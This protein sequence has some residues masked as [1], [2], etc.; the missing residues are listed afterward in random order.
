MFAVAVRMANKNYIGKKCGVIRLTRVGKCPT[1]KA[2][3]ETSYTD[4]FFP[5]CGYTC[6]RVEQKREEEREKR[7]IA[8]EQRRYEAKLLDNKE[9]YAKR[10]EKEVKKSE[11]EMVRE[12]LEK[13]QEEY[14]RH[15]KAFASLT[16]GNNQR[17]YECNRSNYWYR[18]MIFAQKAVDDVERRLGIT[19]ACSSSAETDNEK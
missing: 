3:V 6:K 1:C 7:K 12:R 9:R 8:N 5:Y 2:R 11:L 15:A 10:K 4:I 17:H 13:C 19:N 16:K 18:K 14:D